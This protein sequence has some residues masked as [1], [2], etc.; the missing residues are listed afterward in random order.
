MIREITHDR[1]N[2]KYGQ[3]LATQNVVHPLNMKTV[4]S[5]SQCCLG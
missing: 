4:C 3:I 5:D 2:E 1:D